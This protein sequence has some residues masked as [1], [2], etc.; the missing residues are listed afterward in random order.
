MSPQNKYL[1]CK[2][3]IMCGNC[4]YWNRCQY[5]HDN[6][7]FR[8]TTRNQLCRK[9]NIDEYLSNDS[10]FWPKMNSSEY[11]NVEY[12][13]I[14]QLHNNITYE[15]LSLYSLWNYFIF[16]LLNHQSNSFDIYNMFTQRKR[17]NTFIIL[18][19]CN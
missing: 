19:N 2:T 4:P 11:Y 6:R 13:N 18:S 7:V 5:I 8:A 16:F 1:P 12:Y 17:L 14:P 10:W 15:E 3:H 9:K